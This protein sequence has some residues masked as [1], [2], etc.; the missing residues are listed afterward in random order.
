LITRPGRGGRGALFLGGSGGSPTFTINGSTFTTNQATNASG[1]GAIYLGGGT[2]VLSTTANHFF[3]NTA[4]VSTSGGLTARWHGDA[5]NNW[6]GCNGPGIR[7]GCD[8]ADNGGALAATRG[9]CSPRQS[10]QVNQTTTL[11]ADVLH[12]SSGTLRSPVRV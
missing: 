8:R 12:N 9:W 7:R 3:G 5:T 2:P 6:W 4:G 1:I 10:I 11:T